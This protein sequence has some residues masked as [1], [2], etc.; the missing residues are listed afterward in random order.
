MNKKQSKRWYEAALQKA[1]ERG[2]SRKDLVN[3]LITKLDAAPATAYSWLN[4]SREPGLDVIRRI[5]R[6]V[7]GVSVGELIED[8]PYFLTD[9]SE[10][11]WLDAFRLLS[12]AD[13]QL[14]IQLAQRQ[15]VKP[16]EN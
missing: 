10:R 15:A 6:E 8:D 16:E 7:I 13:K 3:Q 14:L 4:G 12:E 9:D 2:M 1:Q 11:A 5:A